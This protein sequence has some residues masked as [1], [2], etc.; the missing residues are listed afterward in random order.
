MRSILTDDYEYCFI[1]GAPAECEHHIYMGKNRKASTEH[2][3]TVPLC[4][5]CHNMRNDSVHLDGRQV[6]NKK[7][8]RICQ[9]KFEETH[10]REEFLKIIGRNYLG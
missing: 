8:K 6:L 3:F 4:N 2:G 5:G 9:K 7:L 10:S 1:C